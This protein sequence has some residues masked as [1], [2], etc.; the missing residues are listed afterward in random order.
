MKLERQW[1]DQTACRDLGKMDAGNIQVYSYVERRFYCTTCLHTLSADKGTFFET[2]RSERQVVVE[3]LEALGERNSLRALQ[4]LKHH[5]PN[6]ILDWLDLA[7]QHLAAV[8]AE[9]IHDVRLRQAQVDE[10]WTFVKKSRSTA[11][12]TIRPT[13]GTCGSGGLSLCP[14]ACGSSVTSARSVAKWKRPSF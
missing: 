5:S 8:S 9:L 4:R 7:G 11:N 14:V 1:C 2:L 6:T 12:P 13:W 3:V 10:L